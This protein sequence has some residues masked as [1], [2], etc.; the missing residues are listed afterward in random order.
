MKKLLK[1]LLPG[2]ISLI[3][4][5]L[6]M[7][8]TVFAG[9]S[10]I[11]S[12]KIDTEGSLLANMIAV[13]LKFHHLKVTNK[14]GLGGTM[15]LRRAIKS[16]QIDIYPEY[17]G[18]GAVFFPRLNKTIFKSFKKGYEAV[19]KADLKQNN[20]VWLTPARANNTWAIAVRKSFAKRHNIYSMGDFAK[21]VKSGG[22]VR[23]VCSEEFATRED[24]LPAFEKAYGFKL[25][26]S[27]L[28]LLSGGNT[29]QT[30]KALARK[31]NG[32]NFAMAYGTDGSLSSLNL[33]VLKDPKNIEPVY[34]P[35]PII[36]KSVLDRYPQIGVILKPIF[37]TLDTETLQMLNAK[38][39]IEGLPAEKVAKRYLRQKGFIK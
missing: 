15:I 22:F 2:V 24:A 6:F 14:A 12:S 39:A 8:T 27:Q 38:I 31:I 33:L 16:G 29:A 11:V 32:V 25:S 37:E 36:R 21:Y 18:N 17:T 7:Q 4:S 30:E 20:I 1:K 35:T 26:Q 10:I 34:A 23:L 13:S 28:I 19:K 5:L 9:N 3:I